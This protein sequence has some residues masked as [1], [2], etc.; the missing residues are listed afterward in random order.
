MSV[1]IKGR[2]EGFSIIID[3]SSDFF[4]TREKLLQK[5]EESKEFL[6]GAIFTSFI[7]PGLK[8]ADV[9]YLKKLITE[10]YSVTFI[11]EEEEK[12]Q[13]AP[14]ESAGMDKDDELDQVSQFKEK[15]SSFDQTIDKILRITGD[16]NSEK[17]ELEIEDN[18]LK[19]KFVFD[20]MR[21]G[22]EVE[23]DGNVVIFGDVNPG[24][25]VTAKGSIIIMGSF[26]GMAYAGK[27]NEED[28]FLAALKLLPLQIRI[29]DLFAVPPQDAKII[30]NAIVRI[31][32]EEII[33]EQF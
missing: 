33:I 26:R 28:C 10:V 24:A 15:L 11:D 5:F 14:S 22:S 29:R 25:R 17:P 3:E 9:D 12:N 27:D 6:R 32:S 18:N 16:N 23:Y 1:D 13:V 21:S 19:T 20:N 4:E 8:L 2:R 31:K 7:A 30:E